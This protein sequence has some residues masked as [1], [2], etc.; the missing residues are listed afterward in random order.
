MP[1]VLR[2]FLLCIVIPAGL[3]SCVKEISMDAMEDPLIVVECILTDEP[4]QTLYLS[5]TKGASR[6]DAPDLPKAEAV[7]TDLTEEKEVGRF[8]RVADGSWQLAYA[9]IEAHHYRLDISIPGHE[10]L[11]AEQTMPKVWLANADGIS[12]IQASPAWSVRG[13]L[14]VLS[15]EFQKSYWGDSTRSR[16]ETVFFIQQ[17]WT[18][19]MPDYL[20]VYALNYNERTAQLELAEEICTDHPGVDNFNLTGSVYEPPVRDDV[21]NPDFPD[22]GSHIAK[23]Y[24]KLEGQSM[25][26][27]YLR[28]TKNPRWNEVAFMISGSLTGKYCCREA[29]PYG[30][31]YENGGL[32]VHPAPD[33]GYLVFMA[34]SKDYDNYLQEALLY[35][36]MQ[37]STDLSSIYLRDNMHSNISGGLGFFGA[38][39]EL[40]YQWSNEYTY[41][42]YVDIPGLTPNSPIEQ[43]AYEKNICND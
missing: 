9:A 36:N 27:Y 10:P 39:S 4:V 37:A 25:H 1:Q 41:I 43:A 31:Y 34:V 18:Q 24:P 2:L 21:P 42:D 19:Y 20:W 26:R 6:A 33:D 32:A 23:L 7:L 40:R 12:S 3:A 38:K 5:Y 11:W 14:N 17:G 22:S 28:L 15:Q 29:K 30:H 13:D 16:R 8:A 35:H